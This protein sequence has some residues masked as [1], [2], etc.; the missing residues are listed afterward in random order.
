MQKE[1]RGIGWDFPRAFVNLHPD[2][3][4]KTFFSRYFGDNCCLWFLFKNIMQ[5]FFKTNYS[6]SKQMFCLK[7]IQFLVDWPCMLSVWQTRHRSRWYYHWYFH[8]DT[9]TDIFLIIS[10][11]TDVI[12]F[13]LCFAWPIVSWNILWIWFWSD[14]LTDICVS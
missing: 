5:F 4:S 2:R 6:F 9:D 14:T 10:N 8:T 11:R 13:L 1:Y 12:G 7:S 3:S